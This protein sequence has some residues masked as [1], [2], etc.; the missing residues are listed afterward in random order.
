MS[1]AS[2]G[3]TSQGNPSSSASVMP[4][5]SSVTT[6]GA[7]GCYATFDGTD[8]VLVSPVGAEVGL[9][10]NF[11]L[12]AFI[13]PAPLPADGVAF[14]AGRHN[15]GGSNG[16]YLALVND[17][18][19]YK[20]RLIVFTGGGTCTGDATVAGPGTWQHILGTLAGGDITIF[21]DG[22]PA[23]TGACGS[24]SNVESNSVFTVGRSQ[25]GVFPYGGDLDDVSY[26]GQAFTAA[27]D[28]AGLGC[29]SSAALRYSFNAVNVGRPSIVAEDCSVSVPAQVGSAPGADGSDPVFVC[30]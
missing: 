18:G 22:Q 13:N 19:V 17:A 10:D 9:A 25:T 5:T 6:T 15:D 3:S 29:G 27:F 8:D 16:F 1:T 14:V 12:G 23:G 7:G 20:A 21:V 30:P 2:S 24:T 26:F 4:T 28:P 11:A